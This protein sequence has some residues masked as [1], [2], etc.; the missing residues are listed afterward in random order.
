MGDGKISVEPD[1]IRSS[2]G[3]IRNAAQQLRAELQAFQAE[4]AGFGQPWGN[5]D[6]GF[7]I[8]GCYQAIEEVAMECYQ[9]NIAELEQTAD[10]V[11]TMAANYYQAESSNELNINNVRNILG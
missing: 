7:L 9:E 5:D 2:G 8:G 1:Q 11:N 6:L 4:L 3:G 10:K